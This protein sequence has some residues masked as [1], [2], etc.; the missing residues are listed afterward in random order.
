MKAFFIGGHPLKS[1][2]F[3][4]ER[5]IYR[6]LAKIP[7]L[8]E[9][10]TQFRPLKINVGP[11]RGP[12]FIGLNKKGHL[13]IGEIKKGTLR[14]VAWKQVKTYAKKIGKMHKK[15]LES[16]IYKD[17]NSMSLKSIYKGFL[18]KT[19]QLAFLNPSRRCVQLV[20]VAERFS[21]RVLREIHHQKIGHKLDE[22]VKDVKC[23]E[24]NLFKIDSN[25]TIVI[26]EIIL[27]NRRKLAK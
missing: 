19:A 22:I 17:G 6:L 11:E 15:E 4:R 8:L 5:K 14:R 16:A 26:S 20:L 1:K 9:K 2:S 10:D 13:I 23:L 24:V 27:G 21:D 25:K 7:G 12:D 3:S 18:S